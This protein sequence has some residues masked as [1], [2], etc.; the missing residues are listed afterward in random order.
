MSINN[1]IAYFIIYS[2]FGWIVESLYKTY[3]S[4]KP[5][6]SGFL[7]GPLCPIYGFGAIIMLIFLKGYKDNVTL[8]FITAF[9]ILSIWEYIVGWL[10]EKTFKTKYWDYSNN[11][12]NIDGRVCLKNSCFWGI[13]A[14]I[15]IEFLHPPIQ[16][17][18]ESV[19]R[20]F[21][22]YANIILFAIMLVDAIV[23]IIKV[24][25]INISI[26]LLNEITK[27]IKQEI[28]KIKEYAENKANK[29]ETLQHVIE[30]LKEKQ[31]SIK[32]K[33]EKQ[34]A[35]LR[36]AFPTMKNLKISEFLNQRIESIR[37]NK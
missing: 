14:I 2:F 36:K 37:K 22:I 1:L 26:N 13:L 18:M 17:L 15:F 32:A 19:S 12:F 31:E 10:L 34:T 9:F 20:E 28:E 23:S 8:L 3:L 30:E 33:L 16:N 6:N 21:L 35:R 11:K 24:Y 5:V 25:N 27:N 4:K 7:Y 29:N